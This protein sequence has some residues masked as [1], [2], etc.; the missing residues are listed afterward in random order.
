MDNPSV[1]PVAHTVSMITTPETHEEQ[2]QPTRSQSKKTRLHRVTNL[3]WI[4]PQTKLYIHA[5]VDGSVCWLTGLCIFYV[6]LV[7][8][9]DKQTWAVVRHGR[10]TDAFMYLLVEKLSSMVRTPGETLQ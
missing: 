7:A 2:T 1:P 6:S 10:S 8:I 5:L 4:H 3:E 9:L